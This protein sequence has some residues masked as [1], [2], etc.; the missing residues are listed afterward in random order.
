MFLLISQKER[1]R[2][3]QQA[4][5]GAG[6]QNW[7]VTKKATAIL[8]CAMRAPTQIVACTHKW[9]THTHMENVANI[10]V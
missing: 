10:S 4:E 1:P 2:V 7:K 8:Q 6:N 3:C 5:A 9:K